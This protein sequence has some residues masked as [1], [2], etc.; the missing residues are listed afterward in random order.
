MTLRKD[1]A[2]KRFVFAVCMLLGCAV[3]AP[4]GN[5][6]GWRGPDS[7]GHSPE[8]ELPLQWSTTENVRW[9]AELPD[10]GN[11]TPVV[12]GQRVFVTQASEKVNWPPPGAGGPA[13]AY[14]RAVLCFERGNGKL[15]WKG[16]TTYKEKEST[17]PTN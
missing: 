17:H 13:S 9:K 15:L 2:M 6:P 5:W 12:W 3:A 7:N 1:P 4:A 10:E 11:S 8:K 16:E 14:R